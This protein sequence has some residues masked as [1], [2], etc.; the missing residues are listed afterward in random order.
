M[1][2]N[3]SFRGPL[4]NKSTI[5]TQML[6]YPVCQMINPIPPQS[7]KSLDTSTIVSAL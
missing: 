1:S 5:H 3:S 2:I 7:D 4:I 6:K